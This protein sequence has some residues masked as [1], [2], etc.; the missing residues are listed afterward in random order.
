MSIVV[1]STYLLNLCTLVCGTHK[2]IS[3]GNGCGERARHGVFCWRFTFVKCGVYCG[4]IKLY[5]QEY[6]A[7]VHKITVYALCGN[8]HSPAFWGLINPEWSLCNKGR[9][10]SP[11][12]LEPDKLLFDPNLRFL[13][14]DK[15]RVSH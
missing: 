7:C 8:M 4:G 14:I 1:D 11:V 12:D 13:H 5:L 10:Q 6:A 9:R 2:Y 15:H 3:G